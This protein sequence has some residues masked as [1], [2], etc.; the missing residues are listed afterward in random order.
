MNPSGANHM[1]AALLVLLAVTAAVI[2]AA[3]AVAQEEP[4]A[5]RVKAFRDLDRNGVRDEGEPGISVSIKLSQGGELL[6]D[7]HSPSLFNGLSPG[8]YTVA[9]ERNR[10]VWSSCGHSVDFFDPFPSDY[11]PGPELPWRNTTP[12]SVSVTVESGMTVEIV[13]GMQPFDIA[14]ITGGAVLEDG[15]A[16][17]GTL[18]EALVNGQECGT[19][20]TPESSG[21]FDLTILGAGERPGCATP[22]DLV[23][24]R[25]GGVAAAETFTWVPFIDTPGAFEWQLQ[26]LSAMEERA[27]YWLQGPADDL[28]AVGSTVQAVVAGVVCDET[29]VEAAPSTG[30]IV[31]SEAS[32]SSTAGFSRLIVPSESIQP[33]CGR[34]GATV[35]FLA[36]GVEVGSIPWQAGLQRLELAAPVQSPVAGSGQGPE[37]GRGLWA[38]GGGVATTLIAALFATGL[39]LAGGSR[40]LARRR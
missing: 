17:A 7:V 34:P 37:V 24:F 22:G 12:D 3:P 1:K 11:C 27:W 29:V 10:A 2:A 31:L 18:I 21:Q 4:G 35:A 13:F 30:L 8:D 15:Y 36:G 28:P 38:H 16:P 26:H 25:V 5:I 39:L 19:T 23:H 33:G 20:T 32:L 40:L 6:R 14:A 9:A